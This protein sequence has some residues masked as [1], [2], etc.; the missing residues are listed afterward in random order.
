[1]P[2]VLYTK[3]QKLAAKREESIKDTL[4]S[5]IALATSDIQLT[6]EDYAEIDLQ[7]A[8]AEEKYRKQ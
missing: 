8:L 5:L 2:R 1:M 6:K 3:V 4:L 7:V